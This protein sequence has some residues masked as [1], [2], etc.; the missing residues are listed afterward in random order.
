[1]SLC[2]YG[3]NFIDFHDSMWPVVQCNKTD[4]EFFLKP[5]IESSKLY[6][7]GM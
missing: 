7:N 5:L 4:N 3:I 1:M 6:N 2:N